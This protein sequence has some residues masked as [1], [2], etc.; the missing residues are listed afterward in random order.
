MT[1]LMRGPLVAGYQ[2]AFGMTPVDELEQTYRR[3]YRRLTLGLFALYGV[4]VVLA[5][6]VLVGN[7]MKGF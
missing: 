4:V 6:T 7:P 1:S 3:I 5:V 2:E